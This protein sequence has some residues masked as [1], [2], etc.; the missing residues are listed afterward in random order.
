MTLEA[1]SAATGLISIALVFL[2]RKWKHGRW[3]LSLPTLI[4][5]F[6]GGAGLP[7]AALFL[8]YPFLEP[9]PDLQAAVPY[10]PIAGLGLSWAA[11][12][13]FVQGTRD[14]T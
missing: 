7:V 13:S 10:L 11:V 8:F 6:L 12:A 9:K 1:Y 2:V 3:D 4:A 14:G 5:V